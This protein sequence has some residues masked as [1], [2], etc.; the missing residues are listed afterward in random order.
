M[1]EELFGAGISM[2]IILYGEGKKTD[3]NGLVME[4]LMDQNGLIC[5]ND[6]SG[7]RFNISAGNE[8]VLDLTLVSQSLAVQCSWKVVKRSSVGSDHYPI[9]CQVGIGNCE[10]P[11]CALE[12][13]ICSK[14]NWELF[15]TLSEQGINQINKN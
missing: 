4:D 5:L 1:Q 3:S 15:Q 14:A 10:V 6:G 9:I 2:P 8:L 11:A 12:R 13:W 7:T